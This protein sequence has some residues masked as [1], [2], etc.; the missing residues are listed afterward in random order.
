MKYNYVATALMVVTA[1]SVSAPASAQ[2]KELFLY[3]WNNYTPPELIKRFTEETG[4]SVQVDT[5]DNNDTLLSKLQAG[6]GGYD[7]IVPSGG[8]VSAMIKSGLLKK[9]EASKLANFKNVREPFNNPAFDPNREYTVPYM[10]GITAIGYDPKQVEG[11][12]IEDSWKELFEPRPELVGK[13]GM[14]KS[15]DEVVNIAEHYLG[16]E[17][18]TAKPEDGQ[19]IL[20]LLEKQ[21]P[22]VKVY[23][24]E[25]TIDRLAS[26][27]VAIQYMYNGSYHRAQIKQPGL[28]YVLPK[29][30]VPLWGDNFAMPNAAPHPENA[31]IFLNWMMDPKNAAEASNYTGFNNAIAGSEELLAPEL[32]SDPAINVPQELTSR[33][34]DS[35]R[36]PNEATDLRQKIWARLLR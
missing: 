35:L 3:N 22:A 23:S 5:Y 18:C 36:C 31:L 12:K 8:T 34:R 7:I 28:A 21:K 14:L 24:S 4:I 29:E 32:K 16:L 2:S 33:L 9:I 19:K 1:L 20:E 26:G 30:G 6:G 10:W 13:V 25:G 17:S 15:A 11:G 27:E